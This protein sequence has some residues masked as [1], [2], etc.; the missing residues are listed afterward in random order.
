M[1]TTAFSLIHTYQGGEMKAG[2]EPSTIRYLGREPSVAR[3]L[4]LLRYYLLKKIPAI[5]LPPL[6]SVISVSAVIVAERPVFLESGVSPVAVVDAVP[7]AVAVAAVVAALLQR[8]VVVNLDL[9]PRSVGRP[10]CGRP[11]PG[12]GLNLRSIDR[13]SSKPSS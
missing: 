8:H 10:A 4:H 1:D 6:E 2:L 5:I 7:V 9:R 12:M 3:C 13:Y 11:R